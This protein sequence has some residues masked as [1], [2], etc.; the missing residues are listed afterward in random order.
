[1]PSNFPSLL[2]A[3][4]ISLFRLA[5]QLTVCLPLILHLPF[6]VCRPTFRLP[7]P[8][9]C[10]TDRL[11]AAL[12]AFPASHLLSNW[13]RAQEGAYALLAHAPSLAPKLSRL[14]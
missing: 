12:T 13:D 4:I 1:M 10:P 3:D 2:S 14:R 9:R 8:V 7:F 6:P 11:F 5:A